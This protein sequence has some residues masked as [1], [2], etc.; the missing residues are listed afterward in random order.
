MEQH[1]NSNNQAGFTLIEFCVS[2]VIMMVGLLGLL[3][4]VNM[5][6]IHNLDSLLRNEAV[7]LADTE[8]MVSQ[9]YAQSIGTN[10][11]LYNPASSITKIASLAQSGDVTVYSG[12]P[13]QYESMAPDS[14]VSVQVSTK[15]RGGFY[16]YSVNRLV[17][18]AGTSS[19][20]LAVRVSW[21]FKGVK[22]S[23]TISSL[24][25]NPSN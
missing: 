2:V 16:N 5:A 19:K 22:K 1:V 12:T 18:T 13:S 24:I 3:Q 9:T 11:L 17:K 15:A 10:L 21:R 7:S 8:M 20:E 4:A 23:H 25:A 14:P 6:T